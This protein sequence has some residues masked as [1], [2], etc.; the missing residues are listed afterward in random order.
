MNKFYL[1]EAEYPLEGTIEV[2]ARCTTL[3][4]AIEVD[5]R[6]FLV[7]RLTMKKRK[8]TNRKICDTF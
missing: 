2:F 4:P 7:S 5:N 6:G 3:P 1:D 8:D